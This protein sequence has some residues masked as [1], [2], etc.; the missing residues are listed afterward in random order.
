VFLDIDGTLLPKSLEQWFIPFLVQRAYL[1]PARMAAVYSRSLLS[2]RAKSWF[3]LKLRYLAGLELP[4][5]VE[6]AEECWEMVIRRRLFP[7]PALVVRGLQES[8][9]RVVILSGS[10]LFLAVPLGRHFDVNGLI[11]AE[12]EV[13]D[14]VLT[15]GL[16]RPH[17]RGIRKLQA[18]E[19]WLR[20]RDL[21]AAHAGAVA[22]HW[23]DRFL[24]AFVAKPLVVQPGVRLGLMARRHKWPVIRDPYDLQEAASVLR[25]YLSASKGEAKG[26]S[27]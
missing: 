3:D 20:S 16:A 27:E 25:Q 12:P 13:V 21:L 22:D 10:P 26:E 1:R 7:G 23:D 17:P 5:V 14:G 18:A 4:T 2:G 6:W 15:G 8:D 24:L 9:V 19:R 11:C